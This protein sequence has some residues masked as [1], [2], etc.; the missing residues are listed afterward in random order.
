VIFLIFHVSPDCGTPFDSLTD[1][2]AVDTNGR[3]LFQLGNVT[4]EHLDSGTIS[5]TCRCV[6][7]QDPAECDNIDPANPKRWQIKYDQ[8]LRNSQGQIEH[9]DGWIIVKP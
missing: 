5:E 6:C 3:K 8:Y 4:T 2:L 9:A 1:L 7:T